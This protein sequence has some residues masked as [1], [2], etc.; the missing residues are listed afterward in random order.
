VWRVQLANKKKYLKTPIKTRTLH[1]SYTAGHF[2]AAIL[3]PSSRREHNH[4]LEGTR[5]SI[6]FPYP[7]ASLYALWIGS[8]MVLNDV[9][10]NP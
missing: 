6:L 3:V 7:H 10:L 1:L 5:A 9:V 4:I 2:P 8:R